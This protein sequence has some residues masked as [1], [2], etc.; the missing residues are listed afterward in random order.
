MVRE[1][2]AKLKPGLVNW[3]E[4]VTYVHQF[5]H[6]LAIGR[7]TAKPKIPIKDQIT[8]FDTFEYELDERQRT[9]RE[10]IVHEAGHSLF[11]HFASDEQRFAWGRMFI[12]TMR[13]GGEFITPYAGTGL[14][15]DFAD[16]FMV[17]RTEPDT[18]YTEFRE[19]Y[20]FINSQYKEV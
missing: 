7:N 4:G 19:R 12:Q 18:L 1:E 13:D 9:Y 6:G 8:L 3:I 14:M 15:E 20:D 11:A 2:L 17:Y 10:S 16:S 5:G